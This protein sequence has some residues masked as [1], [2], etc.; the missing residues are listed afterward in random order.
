MKLASMRTSGQISR[1]DRSLLTRLFLPNA[2]A[3]AIV[4]YAF[5]TACC[6]GAFV[7]RL[8]LEPLLRERSPLILFEL[9]VA[10]SAMRGGFG[11]GV[12]ATCLGAI[13]SLYFFPRVG[14]V[15]PIAPE[16]RSTV[17]IQL[18]VFVMI[19]V[20]LSWLSGELRRS[21]WNALELADQRNEILES[22]TDGFAAL[23]SRFRFVYLNKRA[24]QLLQHSREELGGKNI[25]EHLP[26]LRGTAVETG[27]REV[28]VRW[29][30]TQFEYLFEPLSRWLEFHVHPA[31]SGGITVY[32]SD[33]SERKA[34]EI[35]LRD[36]LAERDAALEN[37][38]VLS[39]L[40]PICASCKKI[41][42]D[43]GRWQ[44]M[45]AYISGHSQAKFSH[46]LC[47]DCVQRYYE[48]L[49]AGP[50]RGDRGSQS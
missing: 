16:Y 46:G 11:P 27:F 28:L 30:A 35:R 49:A 45:E 2:P 47:P 43:S 9:A 38:R 14:S 44:Q 40:L 1:P 34:A 5:A 7:C 8:L 24:G 41:R 19:C 10:V 3:P 15:F 29:S 26:G 6:L 4:R 39:G 23:D 32:F 12:F 48:E 17:A 22:I 31:G 20:L 33:I 13:G 36:T 42:D 37:V 50:P 25:W 18:T 21:R